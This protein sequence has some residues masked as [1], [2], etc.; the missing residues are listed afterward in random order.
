MHRDACQQGG[1]AGDSTTLGK[2][3][4]L[5]LKKLRAPMA[6]GNVPHGSDDARIRHKSGS[7]TQHTQGGSSS[8][9]PGYAD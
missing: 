3:I 7:S 2:I 6:T 8:Q 9:K 4:G 5:D 1:G